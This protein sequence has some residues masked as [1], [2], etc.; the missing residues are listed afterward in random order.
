M[1][2]GHMIKSLDF[3]LT[4]S[5]TLQKAILKSA[6]P[7]FIKFIC[8]IVYNILYGTVKLSDR[9]K[10]FFKSK[11]R[12]IRI[13]AR[14]RATAASRRRFCIKYRNLVTALLKIGIQYL[15]KS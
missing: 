7:A 3:F 12:P 1:K 2:K 13:L 10:K 4:S 9:N 6:S 5:S 11:A 14:A 8:E 15:K